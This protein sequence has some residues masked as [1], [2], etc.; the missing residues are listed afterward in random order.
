MRN[1]AVGQIMIIMTKSETNRQSDLGV[2][3]RR[4]SHL[5]LMYL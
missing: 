3:G 1:R 5:L 4:V 2:Q